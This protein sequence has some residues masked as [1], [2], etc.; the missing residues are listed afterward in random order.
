MIKALKMVS[1]AN[2]A[3]VVLLYPS[4]SLSG[5]ILKDEDLRSQV[6]RSTAE[7]MAVEEM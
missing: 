4:T 1:A 3:Y 7:D 2:A 6:K 5:G